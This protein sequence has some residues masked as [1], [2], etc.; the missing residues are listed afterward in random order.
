MRVTNKELIFLNLTGLFGFVKPEAYIGTGVW[1]I[2]NELFFYAFLPAFI[3]LERKRL[4]LFY[5]LVFFVFGIGL[6]FAF[7]LINP[8][9]S[10]Q[11]QWPLYVN[12]L[13]QFFL[14]AGGILIGHLVGKRKIIL[15]PY[16]AKYFIV[17]LV[18]I[19]CFYPETGNTVT[20]ITGWSRIVFSLIC[21]LICFFV[22]TS[23]L[24]LDIY[25]HKIFSF[26]GETSYSI[27]LIHP[28]VFQVVKGINVR[29]TGLPPIMAMVISVVCTFI[30]SFICYR[31]LEKPMISLGK[32]FSRKIQE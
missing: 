19:F 6:Y 20:V 17:P 22:Y 26:L 2:G 16:F 28:L 27:Y 18:I 23:Q 14:F 10:L 15:Q 30:S 5:V 29:W 21:F 1:S 3:F 12:P 13:N 9:A 25:S 4:W 11:S 32:S 24:E 31:Y 7:V 8:A